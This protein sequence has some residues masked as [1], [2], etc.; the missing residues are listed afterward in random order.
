MTARC[1]D[2]VAQAS[3]VLV[4]ASRRNN[5]FLKRQLQ[6]RVEYTGKV[7]DR[8]DALASTRDACATRKLT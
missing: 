8:E 1:L 4:S 3:R 6:N 7:R 5:L 2:G